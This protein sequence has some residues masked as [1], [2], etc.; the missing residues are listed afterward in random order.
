VYIDGSTFGGE[1]SI[2]RREVFADGVLTPLLLLTGPRP[3]PSNNP[4]SLHSPY[5]RSLSGPQ[6]RHQS[7]T[8]CSM[9]CRWESQG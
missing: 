2:C 6:T 4:F 9:F 3:P 7:L 1:P 5:K 8:M